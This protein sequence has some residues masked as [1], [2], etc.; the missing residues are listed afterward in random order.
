MVNPDKQ[1]ENAK[2]MNQ[3]KEMLEAEKEKYTILEKEMN[4]LVS[5][6]ANGADQ[7][8]KLSKENELVMKKVKSTA[9]A[10]MKSQKVNMERGQMLN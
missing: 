3:I 4:D 6:N 10:A 1:E 8:Q 5:K 2:E 9:D 7:I